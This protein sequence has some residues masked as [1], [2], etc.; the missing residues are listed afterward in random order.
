MRAVPSG[1][2]LRPLRVTE[3]LDA[4]FTLYRQNFWLFIAVIAVVQ[5]PFQLLNFLIGL[6]L[7]P[8]ASHLTPGQPLTSAQVTSELHF[9]VGE[10][11]VV[12]LLALLIVVLVVPLQTAAF[13]KAVSDRFLGRTTAPGICYR[14]AARHWVDLVLLGVAYLGLVLAGT[15]VVG[16]VVIVLAAVAGGPGILVGV[17]ISIAALVAA[18]ITYS[19][20]VVATPALVLESLGPV[21]AL[22]R[23]WGLTAANAGRAFGTL[24]ALVLVQLLVLLVLG[25]VAALLAAPFG[26]T[27][28]AG[29]TVR[30]L[31]SLVVSLLEAPILATGVTLLYFDLRVR[32]EAFDLELLAQQVMQEPGPG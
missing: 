20:L 1:L 15:A 7:S 22:R 19:R 29:S 3:L 18:V 25:E 16:L 28:A 30:A 13:T 12:G 5:V 17:L 31:G 21:D 4:V 8:S 32:K 24:V 6:G 9:L 11:A 27:T 2:R 14:F 23:S 26:A 10:L